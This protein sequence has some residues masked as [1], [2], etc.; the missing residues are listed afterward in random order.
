MGIRNFDWH[1]IRPIRG[2]AN[3]GF[4]KLCVQ[5]ARGECPS[6]WEFIPTGAPDAGV[7]CYCV[8]PDGREWGWQAKYFPDALGES[9]W[10]QLDKSVNTALVQHPRLVKYTICIPMDLPDP[11]GTGRTTA[12]AQW[13]KRVQKWKQAAAV[14]KM[15]VAFELW[16]ESKLIDLLNGPLHLETL[17]FWFGSH[18]FTEE[19]S[20][21]NLNVALEAAGPRFS[22]ELN[23]KL[24]IGK[25]F[26]AFG[27]TPN[28]FAEIRS[29]AKPLRREV[30]ELA[31]CE[32]SSRG[33][34]PPDPECVKFVEA[35]R[36]VL[37]QI[38][39]VRSIVAGPLPLQNIASRLESLAKAGS[40]RAEALWAAGQSHPRNGAENPFEEKRWRV[41]RVVRRLEQTSAL[42]EEAARL[43]GASVLILDGRAGSGKTH[44]LCD[45]AKQRIE[46]NRPT[47][48][49]L[50]QLFA[51]DANPWTQALEL[52]DLGDL[53]V[54]ELVGCLEAAAMLSNSRALILLDAINESGQIWK[55]HLAAFLAR[56]KSPWIGTVVSVRS[57]YKEDLVPERLRARAAELSHW[58][59]AGNL[60]EAVL[61]FFGH[62][63][64]VLPSTPIMDREYSNPL[65]LKLLCEGLKSNGEQRLPR[66]VHG[67]SLVFDLY[68]AGKNKQASDALRFDKTDSLVPDAL[69][70][71]VNSVVDSDK[72]WITRKAAKALVDPMLPGRTIFEDTLFHRLVA[73]GLLLA[74]GRPPGGSER[75]EV[76]QIAYDRL[77]DH[78][79]AEVLLAREPVLMS[80]G[81]LASRLR[82]D[83]FSTNLLESLMIRVP[84]RDGRELVEIFPEIR[85]HYQY[86]WAFLRSVEWRRHEACL[87]ATRE[88]LNRLWMECDRPGDVL[89]TLLTL[90]LVPGHRFNALALDR[91][92]RQYTLPERDVEWSIYLHDSWQD[93]SVVRRFVDWASGVMSDRPLDDETI[94]LAAITLAWMFTSSNRPLR[95]H[96]TKAMVHL[97]TARLDA[98]A[99][100]VN[101][102]LDVDDPYVLERV[103]AAAYGVALRSH[104]PA[105]VGKLAQCVYDGIFAKEFPP[106]HILLR[107]YARGVIERAIHLGSAVSVQLEWCRPPYRSSWP[108]IPSEAEVALL[109]EDPPLSAPFTVEDGRSRSHLIGSITL[110]NFSIYVIRSGRG[111][112][113]LR[114]R[115]GEALPSRA[116]RLAELFAAGSP[117]ER[118]AWKRYKLNPNSE[119]AKAAWD[120]LSVGRQFEVHHLLDSSK[121][122]IP[123]G[124]HFD[125][126]VIERYMLG[127]VFDLGWTIERFGSFDRHLGYNSYSAPN[128]KPE[129]IGKKY[130]WIAFHEIMAL[131]SDHYQVAPESGSTFHG[132]WQGYFRD[133]DPSCTIR[134]G[135]ASGAG[136]A[137]WWGN[138]PYDKWN[139][140]AYLEWVHGCKD[141]PDFSRLLTVTRPEDAT[142]W[143]NL[144]GDRDWEWNRVEEATG[145]DGLRLWIQFR[146]FLVRRSDADAYLAWAKSN[147]P[148]WP[149]RPS[150]PAGSSVFLGEHPWAPASQ[151]VRVEYYGDPGW[152]RLSDAK[153][154]IHPTV[155][156]FTT[157]EGGYD[158][159]ITEAFS[160][161]LPHAL[162]L[163][164]LGLR[165][166][167]KDAEFVDDK[168]RIVA[169]DPSAE[170]PGP[171]SLL[172]R[173]DEICKFLAKEDLVLCWD[174]RGMKEIYRKA[175]VVSDTPLPGLRIAGGAVLRPG[176][177]RPEGFLTFSRMKSRGEAIKSRPAIRSFPP[178]P[179]A[180]TPP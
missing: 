116:E 98:M 63:G 136:N 70:A 99:R 62:Y 121:P 109:K 176:T 37:A 75:E 74:E 54:E 55:T 159:S 40:K 73:D 28:F 133:I 4:E 42:V 9:Q 134:K 127:R 155:F 77:H 16:S 78:L 135:R 147:L 10:K 130:Q 23:I 29:Y 138:L 19:W 84:E 12:R 35:S 41:D 7:E 113:W 50:G 38:D 52:L 104:S 169:F 110:D 64:L 163:E 81:P 146:S 89:D 96:A 31:R 79:S 111:I 166:S 83:R 152:D 177:M 105:E 33:T 47:I 49:L 5:L 103:L 170:C 132:P 150:D 1:Q 129:R 174:L 161:R 140:A 157:E 39:A 154:E 145:P 85:G 48:L 126:K 65:F 34:C 139:P 60:D 43:A 179:S 2:S 168:E 21:R 167:G 58:G 18:V 80:D 144:N 149:H 13:E 156:E 142:V 162:L 90:A 178:A 11:R 141:L 106:A 26:E 27:R 44:L 153:F 120:S 101:R 148:K 46:S 173:R 8:A 32:Q 119:T 95:D 117:E 122:H 59:F 164:G 3:Q 131:V 57:S 14:R 180:G 143:I 102:F 86:R 61:R 160:L 151:F 51:S 128:S 25:Q 137:S 171:N 165:W 100:L 45:V 125:P 114:Y 76:V 15:T 24:P 53:R 36:E 91:L 88:E 72:R 107:D 115:L 22:P 172:V 175:L 30:E 123:P 158:A 68:L 6:G 124:S 108:K 93:S 92:L 112:R 94:D 20:R 69:R 67:I 82:E 118:Q 17:P 66:G 71:I 87:D 56:I 97:L